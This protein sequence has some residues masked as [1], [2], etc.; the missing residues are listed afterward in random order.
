MYSVAP[1]TQNSIKFELLISA[2]KS[3]T[4]FVKKWGEQ[5]DRPKG[6]YEN[7]KSSRRVGLI[8]GVAIE[9]YKYIKTDNI[10][11]QIYKHIFMYGR[12]LFIYEF[13]LRGVYHSTLIST[14]S[15]VKKMKNTT[16]VSPCTVNDWPHPSKDKRQK[17]NLCFLRDWNSKLIR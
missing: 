16:S 1:F 15:K 3:K 6:T 2:E 11:L 14:K 4:V 5:K 10:D 12:N 7:L 8:D 17:S 9:I 13:S